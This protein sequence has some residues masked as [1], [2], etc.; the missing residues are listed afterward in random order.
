MAYPVIRKATTGAIL[1][2]REND[3]VFQLYVFQGENKNTNV[4]IYICNLLNI[5]L[6]ILHL[7][8][9]SCS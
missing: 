3:V 1:V 4:K 8:M 5:M 7:F 2:M 9:Q 6:I